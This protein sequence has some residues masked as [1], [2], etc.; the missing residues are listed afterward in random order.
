MRSLALPPDCEQL[1][2][3]PWRDPTVEQ[4]GYDPR[5]PYVE[6]FWLGLLGPSATW[7]VRYVA[8]RFDVAQDG[9]ALDLEDCAAAIGIGRG[10]GRSSPLPKTLRRCCQFRVA[11]MI[12]RSTIE[13]RSKLA[14][15][16]ERQLGRLPDPLRAEH[17]RWIEQTSGSP[18]LVER[19]RR[20]ALSLLELG[21]DADAAERQLERWK[22]P[23]QM[24]NE[25]MRWAVDRWRGPSLAMG[26]M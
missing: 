4:L 23:A 25:A 18:V 9:F 10:W 16:T 3:R 24:A 1:T 7:L 20:L 22:F 19:A 5:S 14:P 15:L 12:N 2:V 11:R 17:A 21:E 26:G 13:M 6:R 8:D